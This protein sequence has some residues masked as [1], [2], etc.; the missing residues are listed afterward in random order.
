MTKQLSF[1]GVSALFMGSTAV[2][3]PERGL[4]AGPNGF[5]FPLQQQVDDQDR[6][7]AI[8]ALNN[9]NG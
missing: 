6:Q 1:P 2:F 9:K 4:T 3:L 7:C 8:C 5:W